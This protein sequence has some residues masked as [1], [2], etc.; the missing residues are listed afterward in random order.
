MT[1]GSQLK[2]LKSALSDAGLSRKNIV[3]SS[4]KKRKRTENAVV[5]PERDKQKAEQ[6]LREIHERLNPFDTKVTKLKHDVGGRKLK[7][8]TG[9]PGQ[10]KQA[11]IEQRNKTLLEEYQKKNRA[12]GILDRRF[13]ENDPTMTPEERMLE[14]FTRERQRVSKGTIFNLEEEELTHYGQSLSLMDDFDGAGLTLDD[15]DEEANNGQIDGKTVLKSHFGGFNDEE[16]NE[17]DEY[18]RQLEKEANENARIQVDQEFDSI[19]NLVFPSLPNE[20]NDAVAAS[21]VKSDTITSEVFSNPLIKMSLGE[22]DQQYDQ[23]V[24]ELAFDKRAKPKD[25]TKTEEEV[26]LEEK[27]VLEKAEKA[28]LQRMMG[29]ENE[30]D[31]NDNLHRRKRT[32]GG[33]DLEDNFED[34][35]ILSHIG[36]GLEGSDNR[37]DGSENY[38]E[39][40][41]DDDDGG[42]DNDD[43]KSDREEWEGLGADG[44][45][46]EAFMSKR[47][48]KSNTLGNKE[49]PFTFPCPASHDEFLSIL[50]GIEEQHLGTV[51]QRIRALHHPS[52]DKDNP[53]K[54]HAF[55][56]VLIDHVLDVASPPSPN[57]HLIDYLFP[58][59]Y[60]LTKMYPVPA[61]NV[62]VTKLTLMHKNLVCG[63]S[64][65]AALEWARTW[66]GTAELVFLRLLGKLWSSSDMN[67]AVISPARIL[68]G[69]YLSLARIRSVKDI[70]SGLFLCTIILQY[71]VFSKRL[72]PEAI[73]FLLCALL[74]LASHPFTDPALFPGCFPIPDFQGNAKNLRFPSGDVQGCR[75]DKPNLVSIMSGDDLGS[76]S[77]R[78]ELL[79]LIFRLLDR[80]A[81][82]NKNVDGFIELYTPIA[83]VLVKLDLDGF[84][85]VLVR[86]RL[87]LQDS[88]SRLLKFSRNSRRPLL[89]Q[90]HRPIPIASIVPKFT[91]TTS[92]Y[93]RS[94]DPD[95]ER[96]TAAKLRRQ[97]KEERK[98]AIREL[99]KDARFLASVQQKHDIEG[100]EIYNSKLKKVF[101]SIE[102]ERSEQKAMERVKKRE[103]KRAKE[104]LSSGPSITIKDARREE[105]ILLLRDLCCIM[106]G[107]FPKAGLTA[108]DMLQD[109]IKII[110]TFFRIVDR[111]LICVEDLFGSN[112][113]LERILLTQ[114]IN[115]GCILETWIAEGKEDT[116]DLLT[117]RQLKV[118]LNRVAANMLTFVA[119]ET[120]TQA[121]LNTLEYCLRACLEFITELVKRPEGFTQP[122]DT[123]IFKELLNS[124]ETIAVSAQKLCVIHV[125]NAVIFD[126]LL[127]DSLTLVAET[128]LF[129]KVH[130]ATN[131]LLRHVISLVDTHFS[132]L[133]DN[134]HRIAVTRRVSSFF[135]LL[136]IIN[137]VI[138]SPFYD[139][140]SISSSLSQLCL[141]R[142]RD[143]PD[144]AWSEVDSR[145]QRILEDYPV[146]L[147][148]GISVVHLE[149]RLTEQTC[150]NQPGGLCVSEPDYTQAFSEISPCLKGIVC[151]CIVKCV[152]SMGIKRLQQIGAQLL[153]HTCDK[154]NETREAISTHLRALQKPFATLGKRKRDSTSWQDMIW[155]T[156]VTK[157]SFLSLPSKLDTDS[158]DQSWVEA[159]I[160]LLHD[161][162]DSIVTRKDRQE[163][164]QFLELLS[165]LTCWLAHCDGSCYTQT[166][167]SDE[168]ISVSLFIRF[169]QITVAQYG[170]ELPSQSWSNILILLTKSIAH[171]HRLCVEDVNQLLFIISVA[172]KRAERT[173][174]LFAGVAK[175]NLQGQILELII[176][177][178]G[179]RN[180]IIR[181]L[182]Y[183]QLLDLTADKKKTPYMLLSPY[184]GQISITVVSQISENPEY[185]SQLCNFLD[186]TPSK[187]FNLTSNHFLPH[188]VCSRNEHALKK[189]AYELRKS[190]VSLITTH[191][192]LSRV[193]LL[194]GQETT[195]IVLKFILDL[196]MRS[197][198]D[199]TEPITTLMVVKSTVVPLLGELVICMGD[200]HTD[201]ALQAITKVAKILR[202][203]NHNEPASLLGEYLMG[204]VSHLN[205]VLQDVHGKKTIAA[206][207]EVMRGLGALIKHVGPQTTTVAPQVMATLQSMLPKSDLAEDTLHTWYTFI[208]TLASRDV[209][210]YI[211]PTSAAFMTMWPTLQQPGREIIKRTFHYLL[212]ENI[213]FVSVH[214][215]EFVSLDGVPEL[216]YYATCLKIR[217]NSADF[218]E[219]Y[220][221]NL[222]RRVT[223]DNL[224][225][226]ELSLLELQRFMENHQEYFLKHASGDIFDPQISK[227]VMVLWDVIY[228]DGDG[229]DLLQSRALDCLG[230]LG[231]VD[232]DRLELSSKDS[233]FILYQN[234]TDEEESIQFALYLIT[235]VLLSS[236]RSTSDIRFQS[237]LA[238]A[239]QELLK[240]CGFTEHLISAQ[241]RNAV[242]TKIRSRWFDLPQ[243]VLETCAPL[244]GAKYTRNTP[245]CRVF[246]H[247][248][249]PSKGTYRE[250]LQDWTASLIDRVALPC[251]RAIF[252]VFRLVVIDRDVG[253]ARC[254][255]PHLVLH[256]LISGTEEDT[257]NLKAEIST[258]LRDQ[259]RVDINSPGEHRLLCAQTVFMLMDHLNKWLRAVR[260]DLAQKRNDNRRTRV[261]DST[262]EM[263][264]NL[265]KVDSMLSDIDHEMIAKAAFE[266][267][268]F[269]RSL[270]NF[271]RQ[272]QLRQEHGA[273]LDNKELQSYYERLHEI[274][275]HLNEPDGMEG[276]TVRVLA[277]SFEHQIRQHQSTGRWTSAQ[278]C[279]E[280][281]LL[282]TPDDVE[283]H[284]GFLRCLR[285]LGHYD[286]LQTHIKGVLSRY[287]DW[288]DL[289][290]GFQVESA[291]MVGDWE[292]VRNLC[293]RVTSKVPS[294]I[295]LARVLLAMCDGDA[296]EV[297]NALENAR[298]QLAAPIY[299]AGQS[300]YRRMYETVLN[301]HILRD[302]EIIYTSII[303]PPNN[304][305]KS[306]F[307]TLSRRLDSTLPIFR[308]REPI[309]SLQRITL[310]LSKN[311]TN[312]LKEIIG[313]AW[314]STAKLARKA[315]HSQ[316]AYSAVLQAERVSAPFAFL[317]NCR[318]VKAN[319]EPIRALQELNNAILKAEL[320]EKK[321]IDPTEEL[322]FETGK[323]KAKARM[324]RAR[325]MY[326]TERFDMDAIHR[327]FKEAVSL[328]D[329]WES[330]HFHLGKFYD[331]QSARIMAGKDLF[332]LWECNYQTIKC[333][334][335]TLQIG[336]KYVYQTMPRM[337]TLWLDLGE[338]I[339]HS[340][341]A[342]DRGIDANNI[343]SKTNSK[344]SHAIRSIATY[345]WLSAFPQIVSRID[346][347]NKG[348]FELLSQLIVRI[349]DEYPRQALW[350]FMFVVHSK[351][352]DRNRRAESILARLQACNLLFA[353]NPS[354]SSI[355]PRIV[356]QCKAMTD[357]LLKLCNY[358]ILDDPKTPLS[359][360]KTFPGL[361][362]LAPS[363]LIVPLQESITARL[364]SES[365]LES[366]HKPFPDHL[367]TIQGFEDAIDVMRSLAK[368][369]KLTFQADNGKTFPFLGK[370]KDDLRKDAR[371]MDFNAI[372]NKLLKTDSDARRRQLRIRTYTVITLNEEAGLIQWVPNT[373]PMRP[374]LMRSY[375]L[376]NISLWGSKVSHAYTK[377]KELPAEQ[378]PD[379][380]IREILS[381]YP[382]VF[383]EWFLDTFPEPT[384]WLTSRLSFA[385]T[386]AVM[387]MVGFILGLGDRHSEN[388]L[389]DVNTGD[390]I[391][392]DFDCLF[393]RGKK[394][395][396]PERVPFRL[397]Q[398]M[399]DGLGVTNVDGP[400]RIACEI[401]MGLL[402]RN[403]DC[404]M[405][406][407]DAFIHDPLVE[408]E[409]EKKRLEKQHK[410]AA[411]KKKLPAN[412]LQNSVDLRKLAKNALSPI[413]KKLQG[414]YI[415]DEGTEEWRVDKEMS[416][417]NLV[418]ALIQEA[419]SNKNLARM[420]PG[421]GAFL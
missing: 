41:N 388:V 278:S 379:F 78:L 103:K 104:V 4:G 384:A 341:V 130:I 2:Q 268:A 254:L 21:I 166:F 133:L 212:V 399:Q 144:T 350:L 308:I 14:R 385:R 145:L 295:I 126:S 257:Q 157:L 99:R 412:L 239:I 181:G 275:A 253:I 3:K 285:N 322:D 154:A 233:S 211:G 279:W 169:C 158:P 135:R 325:W 376:R 123:V 238:Y 117:P 409:N 112:H 258:V 24:R 298:L 418:D 260:Q 398:N 164:I 380:F 13:G 210:Q 392:V 214:L 203:R 108:W 347:S 101:S 116:S 54:L 373:V 280:L 281:Q 202:I 329:S 396:T 194:D 191:E 196:L 242:P 90:Q 68:I 236:Y 82:L 276:V 43:E 7:G 8:V 377:I 407:L 63:L 288:Y 231:A 297:C 220:L 321:T 27:E 146:D 230:R 15:D 228:R 189:V 235:G 156:F 420:Y 368:P 310:G 290:S 34:E 12:G 390:I 311:N 255:L 224:T 102:Q 374:L 192:V 219:G 397:T 64:Q 138:K 389:M 237:H 283:S 128:I 421:W 200:K 291:W 94:K 77:A 332:S 131:T 197:R 60:A 162:S 317:Q 150:S 343:L 404:L 342:N 6:K 95:A 262:H 55:I 89:L 114:F 171:A 375:E 378:V 195:D 286:S 369:R 115:L 296:K 328:A 177:H 306:A 139:L 98:G 338:K 315:G 57:L 29:E 391:H 413:K 346:H 207:Q 223:N 365:S 240:F 35:N 47:T 42:D 106:I 370:P 16:E 28:R 334:A 227:M 292:S 299:A 400:F 74:C 48:A 183:V 408:W 9:K 120:R 174:R 395:E 259:V 111:A 165:G 305:P 18:Q 381:L 178:L 167:T 222:L 129:Q 313:Q 282:Q 293:T 80:F 52:L 289:L 92:N 355:V 416:T 221:D 356:K 46:V 243:H 110:Q 66:P 307:K 83:E 5:P 121:S 163:V 39:N 86:Q 323:L 367:P 175:G 287:P 182:A 199:A 348:V 248:I 180:L 352:P 37:E 358:Q 198:K 314:L 122:F 382:P 49:L 184:I 193:F 261:L 372:I 173:V 33:D 208:I 330:T 85:P 84:P 269:A 81:D 97:V 75:V 124:D 25:R 100:A 26:A 22:D 272:I 336:S 132:M 59:I 251:A 31:H 1:K 79:D 70:A 345:K 185:L 76:A 127:L 406:V 271:E 229:L 136:C 10:S 153:E 65:G 187:F 107:E 72:Y 327:G 351:K 205:E 410:A 302:M 266:C 161:V 71:E 361:A 19:R 91:T 273:S 326:D 284:L 216:E 364:P 300:S 152:P 277:P 324:L 172:I 151:S 36:V 294:E 366:S 148:L 414:I 234:F 249:Y 62:C 217:Q 56:R 143:G 383:H 23:F 401:T 20:S 137:S 252:D 319:G 265:V 206:K 303:L 244:L 17:G 318:L 88:V 215:K 357:E 179:H 201:K 405:S 360:A 312:E 32:R 30:D 419:K 188:L 40:N 331:N 58:H 190:P 213:D 417:S 263:E 339:P 301:L 320:S 267:K 246:N 160:E 359:L 394:L 73:N 96:A 245:T 386:A 113:Q 316:T 149:I 353:S 335:K 250:W 309:L 209:G 140:L 225:V 403:Q 333:Y 147:P 349:L 134:P 232:P 247:P 87:R 344:V 118:E 125:E 256:V 371:L 67:H 61:A 51:V 50:D 168:K 38:S 354:P 241:S 141:K 155:H 45:D 119:G 93:L 186:M 304:K 11:G 363:E 170:K 218:P 337:L 204:V 362:K 69:M 387:S 393:E 105:I 159:F 142:L 44:V 402:R 274:Y 340:S 415:P 53:K 411:P 270:M 226:A 176:K 264:I 109:R